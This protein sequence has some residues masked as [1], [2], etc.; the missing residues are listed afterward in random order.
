MTLGRFWPSAGFLVFAG[1]W[2]LLAALLAW[3]ASRPDLDRAWDIIERMDDPT[4]SALTPGELR[5]LARS[6]ERHP[7]L[8]EALS[9][10]RIADFVEPTEG[11]WIAVRSAHLAVRPEPGGTIRIWTEVRAH[12]TAYPLTVSFHASWLTQTV[13]FERDGRKSFD[14]PHNQPARAEFV[15]VTIAPGGAVSSDARPFEI[16]VTGEA[17]TAEASTDGAQP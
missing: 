8:I 6:L 17:V 3:G 5:S 9:G 1:S 10:D 16:R 13:V 14:L 2:T 4:F 15:Q 12:P 7:P 11:K